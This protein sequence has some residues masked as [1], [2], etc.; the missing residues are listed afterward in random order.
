MILKDENYHY[1]INIFV[2]GITSLVVVSSRSSSIPI[3][4]ITL[5]IIIIIIFTG[6]IIINGKDNIS[7]EGNAA[8]LISRMLVVMIVIE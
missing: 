1:I 5:T 6:L 7:S 2:V 4:I 8:L 3:D